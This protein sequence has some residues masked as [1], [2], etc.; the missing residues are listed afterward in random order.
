MRGAPYVRQVRLADP[1]EDTGGSA[2]LRRGKQGGLDC[3][4]A[5][6]EIAGAERGAGDAA[7][8]VVVAEVAFVRVSR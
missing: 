6:I 1:S 4:H 8:H 7:E 2:A 3:G 5:G